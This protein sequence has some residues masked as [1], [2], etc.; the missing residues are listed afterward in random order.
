MTT[1]NLITGA[2]FDREIVA[3][4][5]TEEE[6]IR[7]AIE[8]GAPKGCLYRIER[9]DRKPD[10]GFAEVSWDREGIHHAGRHG[11]SRPA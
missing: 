4:Y 1:Y 10:G 9:S 8:G 5:A 3:S 11:V 7:A 6:A 2:T